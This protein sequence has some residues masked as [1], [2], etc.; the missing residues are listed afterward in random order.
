LGE[1]KKT[2]L[3]NVLRKPNMSEEAVSLGTKW[4]PD[5]VLIGPDAIPHQAAMRVPTKFKGCTQVY[6]IFLKANGKI[7]CSC[8]RY[9]H[10]LADAREVNVAKWYNG[11]VMTYIRESFKAGFEPFNF[12]EGCVSHQ[13]DVDVDNWA[14]TASLH[15][16]PSSQCNL[17][18]SACICTTE[19]LSDNPPPR[20][21]L[22]FEVFSK[23][24]HEFAA[25]KV[26]IGSVAFVG[27]GEP[28]FNSD[29]PKMARLSKKLFPKVNMYMD[30]NCNFG[31]K[32]AAEI[33]NCGLNEIRLS[34]DGVSQTP[35]AKYRRSGDFK[36]AFAFA[37]QL[38]I[39]V[40]K[41]KSPTKLT[42][43][44]ILFR[45]ND[46]NEEILK[47]LQM[48]KEIGVEID[49][50]ATFGELASPR[51]LAEIHELVGKRAEMST[52]LDPEVMGIDDRGIRAVT[53]D[54]FR[55]SRRT[56]GFQ[57]LSRRLSRL[58]H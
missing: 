39:E 41:Q 10:I 44:Y 58:W 56:N 51:K 32:R 50:N 25:E 3:T 6:Q 13:L 29:L 31:P 45:H 8:M 2:N 35:Y 9:Y 34:L 55:T 22:D 19:R 57:R 48:A 52:N 54:G 7:S 30:T 33:A 21:N 46:T 23:V 16:E 11:E 27:F 1:C 36:K 37:K 49:F 17:F 47:A 53:G 12:C 24:V 20:F 38:A 15:I 18:C 14:T 5:E 40:R 28:L 43:K 26:P 42:W 4:T